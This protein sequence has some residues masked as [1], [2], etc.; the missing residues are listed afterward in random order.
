MAEK[1]RFHADKNSGFMRKKELEHRDF[2]SL[3]E[4][5][6]ENSNLPQ[7]IIMKD[8]PKNV[9]HSDWNQDDTARG[10]DKQM[11]TDG[12]G[13]KKHGGRSEKY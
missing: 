6:S 11:D 10:V 8:Y 12:R 2:M 1:K 13:M 3:S 7:G 9:G 5:M 4:N